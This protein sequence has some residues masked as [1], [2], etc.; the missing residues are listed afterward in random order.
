LDGD[1]VKEWDSATDAALFYGI[2][3]V[4]ITKCCLGIQKTSMGYIWKYKE[5]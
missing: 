4:N 2:N 1:F 3:K 5:V